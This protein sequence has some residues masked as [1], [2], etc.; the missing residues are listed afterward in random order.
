MIYGRMTI[1]TGSAAY[2]TTVGIG[3]EYVQ[4]KMSLLYNIFFQHHQLQK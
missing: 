2:I 1:S 4:L 3:T